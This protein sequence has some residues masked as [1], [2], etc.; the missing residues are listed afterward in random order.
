MN[1]RSAT[2]NTVTQFGAAEAGIA[3]GRGC[4]GEATGFGGG[5]AVSAVG[6]AGT[7]EDTIGTGACQG[8]CGIVMR[9]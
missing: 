9:D 7:D 8:P 1:T 6:T 3:A 2:S 4:M 5:A